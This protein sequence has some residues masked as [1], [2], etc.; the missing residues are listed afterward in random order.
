[1]KRIIITAVAQIVLGIVLTGVVL[2]LFTL[3]LSMPDILEWIAVYIGGFLT[4][5]L[6]FLSVGG[7]IAWCIS[8]RK[9]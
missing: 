7:F 3:A 4:Y 2:A 6:F 8:E 1:M 9:F 5:S